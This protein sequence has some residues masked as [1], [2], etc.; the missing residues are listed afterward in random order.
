MNC[1]IGIDP[2][3]EGAIVVL[4]PDG[5]IIQAYNM[6]FLSKQVL[7]K[8]R[9][10]KPDALPP[11]KP[12]KENPF[13]YERTCDFVGINQ[14]IGYIKKNHGPE[15]DIYV[16]NITHL[17]GLPSATNFKLGHAVGVIY[18]ALTSQESDFYLLPTKKWQDAVWSKE[19]KAMKDAKKKEKTELAFERLFPGYT[20]INSDG[21][22][23]AALI[24]YAGLR[25]GV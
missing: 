2:G 4:S 3:V 20:G 21:V 6:P 1:V 25:G 12:K 18:S 17:F 24:A 7:K 9:K 11:K 19:E 16:E 14:I 15:M 13:T 5:K 22:R 10:P 8:K 23:D